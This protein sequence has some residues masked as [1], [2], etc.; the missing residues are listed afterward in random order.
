MSVA[1]SGTAINLAEIA[2][3]MTSGTDAG[4]LT[5]RRSRLRR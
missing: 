1:S 4:N 5:L 3:R 2:N